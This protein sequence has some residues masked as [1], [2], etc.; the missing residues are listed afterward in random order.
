MKID[1]TGYPKSLRPRRLSVY[2][3]IVACADAFDAAT[4][5]R[6]YQTTPIQPDQVLREIWE[7]PRRGHDRVIV[8]AL[9]NLLGI[10][11][12]GTCVILDTYEVGIVQAANP[13]PVHL[14]RPMVKIVGTPDGGSTMTGPVV[15]L[16]EAKPE[17]DFLRTIIKVTDPAKY[18]IRAS[19]HFV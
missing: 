14:H 19:D 16:A 17:G 6:V 12:V 11:P 3:K 18:G 2:S 1:L 7:N 10:Y 8:K 5:R 13:D 4:T 9:I 15:N